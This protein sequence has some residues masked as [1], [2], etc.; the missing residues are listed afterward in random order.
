MQFNVE[1]GFSVM[2]TQT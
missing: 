2:Q 1:R